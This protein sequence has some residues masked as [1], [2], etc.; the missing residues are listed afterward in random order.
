MAIDFKNFNINNAYSLEGQT[1]IVTGGST[2]LGL[3]ITRCLISAGAKVIVLS[4]ETPEQAAEALAEFGEQ[5]VFYQFDITNTDHTQEMVDKIIADHGQISIL[6]NNAGNHCKKY[7]WDMSVEDYVKVLN[8]HL[9]GAFALTKA[10]VP[11]MKT[12]NYGNIVFMASMTSYI[13]QPQVSGYSTAKAGYL[14]LIHTLTAECAEFGIRVNAIAPGWIDTP[15]F[16]KAT[17]HD[18][19]RLSKIMGRIPA[20]RVGDP[21]DVGMCTAFLCSDAARYITGA[22]IPVDGGALIGF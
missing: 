11:H 1:A 20:K 13:G 2:G 17:D 10:L 14:G 12:F 9:V 21:M 18:S 4:F 3:A 22:C 8:V 7:I 15:M 16:H 5:A 6:I 19:T